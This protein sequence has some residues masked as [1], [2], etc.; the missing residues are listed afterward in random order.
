M[1]RFER[2]LDG[3]SRF[4][5][6]NAEAVKRFIA[7]GFGAGILIGLDKLVDGSLL[8]CPFVRCDS[9]GTL[10]GGFDV[11]V[12]NGHL[13]P[14]DCFEDGIVVLRYIV[15][16]FLLDDQLFQHPCLIPLILDDLRKNVSVSVEKRD[17]VSP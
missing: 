9:L 5:T 1:R 12:G 15:S 7:N 13:F 17:Y 3:S 16:T 6:G 14:F 10:A 8:D 2:R 11:G 4:E